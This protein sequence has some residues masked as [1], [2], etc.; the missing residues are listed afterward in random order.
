MTGGSGVVLLGWCSGS[1]RED[2]E[3]SRGSHLFGV[4]FEGDLKGRVSLLIEKS[5]VDRIVAVRPN[6]K[7]RK[8]EGLGRA[9]RGVGLFRE[10]EWVGSGRDSPGGAQYSEKD[11]VWGCVASFP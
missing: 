11:L 9:V 6:E 5:D 1:D 10:A 4:R 3:E 2:T 8:D 7:T